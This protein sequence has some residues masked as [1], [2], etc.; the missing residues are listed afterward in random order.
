MIVH[1]GRQPSWPQSIERQPPPPLLDDVHEFV[2][3]HM[4]RYSFVDVQRHARD[5]NRFD[6]QIWGYTINMP[7]GNT[8]GWL[9]FRSRPWLSAFWLLWM[10]ENGRLAIRRMRAPT[11][12]LRHK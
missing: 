1:W 10:F 5:Y 3:D 11:R 8:C 12:Y 9:Q 4:H 2:E 6:M 7:F